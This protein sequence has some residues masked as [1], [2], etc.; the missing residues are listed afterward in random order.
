M[1]QSMTGFAT[2][3]ISLSLTSGNETTAT[4]T[5]KTVNGRFFDI[6]CKVPYALAAIEPLITQR[7]RALLQRGSVIFSLQLSHP[8]A[9]K[10]IVTPAYELAAAYVEAL[11]S[12]QQR[13]NLPGEITIKDLAQFPHF[14]ETV[15]I[16]VPETTIAAIMHACEAL[17]HDLMAMRT[18][19]GEALTYDLCSN[20]TA[21]ESYIAQLVPRAE[22]VT[23]ERTEY[24][25]QQIRDVLATAPEEVR[26]AHLQA[27]YENI[28]K[29]EVN[30]EL[31]RLKAHVA[32][33]YQTLGSSEVVKGKKIDFI[34]Q[35]MFR[36]INT[37][38]AK[39]TDAA[40]LEPIINIKTC[41]ERM[42]EQGQNIV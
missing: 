27:L 29:V 35:E 21:I 16:P 14:L 18:R 40:S 30:E 17:I 3:T 2:R 33:L 39:L 11:H 34:L 8:L 10:T 42:R 19:E 23:K 26:A 28:E 9:L 25:L 37:L 5:L 32:A 20:I 12:V 31:V 22:L 38:G 41:L 7:C 15:D 4:L 6:N 24:L 1:I 36:E 13:L